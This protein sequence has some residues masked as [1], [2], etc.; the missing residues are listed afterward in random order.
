MLSTDERKEFHGALLN[1]FPNYKN[2]EMM[3]Y[4]EFCVENKF[5]VLKNCKVG[6]LL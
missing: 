3:L 6:K 4:F 2:L 5:D 1:A